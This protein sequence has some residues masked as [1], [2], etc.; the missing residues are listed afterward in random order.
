[1]AS[2]SKIVRTYAWRLAIALS[3]LVLLGQLFGASYYLNQSNIS[4]AQFLS[5]VASI[6]KSRPFHT[7]VLI[8]LNSLNEE[9]ERQERENLL[10]ES[11]AYINASTA[12]KFSTQRQE[13]PE[14]DFILTQL[15]PDRL[16]AFD[17]H[18]RMLK[19]RIPWFVKQTAKHRFRLGCWKESCSQRV[20]LSKHPI[21]YS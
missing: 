8:G 3:F 13:S 9:S 2:N 1:M 14:F 5:T 18:Y 4:S 20:I 11:A 16:K 15:P 19:P 21:L 12:S 17:I 7:V 10:G 6:E